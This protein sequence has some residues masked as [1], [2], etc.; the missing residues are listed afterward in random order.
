MQKIGTGLVAG[1][2]AT[3]VLSVMMVAKSM[4][5]IMPRLDVIAV[6]SAMMGS[7][8]MTAW[9]GHFMIGT[10]AWGGGFAVLY[11]LIPGV[12]PR[13]RASRSAPLHGLASW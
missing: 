10:L 8:A 9:L 5:G 11:G 12:L 7:C 1:F 4:M 13:Q 2:I 6:L 3:V